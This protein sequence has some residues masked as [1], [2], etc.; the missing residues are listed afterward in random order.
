MTM[1]NQYAKL[2]AISLRSALSEVLEQNCTSGLNRL[3]KH[4]VIDKYDLHDVRFSKRSNWSVG[5]FSSEGTVLGPPT[6]IYLQ[7]VC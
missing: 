1:T 5:E 6:S 4:I 7:I 3:P 2:F